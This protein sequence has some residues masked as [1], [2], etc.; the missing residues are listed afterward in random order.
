MYGLRAAIYKDLK[1][2]F[3]KTGLAALLLPLALLLA[4]QFGFEKGGWQPYVQPFPIAVRDED[5]TLMSRSLISQMDRIP[6]FSQLIRPEDGES[7]EEL[8]DSG[9]AAVATIPKD[10][11]YDLYDM[12]DCPIQLTLNSSMPL[13]ASL[14]RSMFCSVMDIIRSDQAAWQGLYAFYYG[15]LT[16]EQQWAM[17]EDASDSLIQDALRRQTVFDDTEGPALESIVER[18]LLATLLAVIVLF[19]SLSA[20]KTLPE[21]LSLGVLPRFRAAGGALPSFLLAKLLT[22]MLAVFPTLLLTVALLRVGN[23]AALLLVGIVLLAGAFG[24]LLAVASWAGTSAA[25]QRFGNLL[26]LLSLVFGGGL[27]PIGLLP[28]PLAFLSRLTLPYYGLLGVEAVCWGVSPLELF[29]LLLPVLLM[30]AAGFAVALPGLRKR[31]VG[32]QRPA[33]FAENEELPVASVNPFPFRLAGMAGVK[34]RAMSGGWRGLALL[35]SAA[36]LCGIVAAS[37]QDAKTAPLRIAV[38]DLDDSDSSR[39]LVELL[40]SHSGISLAVCGKD[41][42]IRLLLK[43]EVE[44]IFTIGQGYEA[45]L[46]NDRWE[47][48]LGYMEAGSASSAQCVREIIAGQFSVQRSSLRVFQLAR[49]QTGSLDGDSTER[50][51]ECITQAEKRAPLL[52]EIQAANGASLS[53]PFLPSPMAFASLAVLLTLFTAAPW[54]GTEGQLVSRRLRS[55]PFGRLLAYGSGCL[56]LTILGFLT[57]L[58]VL[59]PSGAFQP[60]PVAAYAFCAASLSQALTRSTAMEGRVDSFA[61]FLALFLCLL[62]GCFLDISQLSPVLWSLSMLTP[63]GLVIRA[64]SWEWPTCIFLLAQGAIF[65][66]VAIPGRK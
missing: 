37:A 1:L 41:E 23:I 59:L 3:R 61:P 31:G 43:G 50:L 54:S 32:R 9:A 21:E 29:Q 42:G 20:V 14:F 52:Y 5:N 57:A 36:L 34:L 24:L 35:L 39:K 27:W 16:N 51:M 8:L 65:L 47:P 46:E 30:G 17:Y 26:L 10:F 25:A 28:A 45:T 33:V 63:P 6:L 64:S 19:F 40:S 4:L 2:F 44:G 66:R 49:Q 15:E 58:A 13:E 12:Q 18:K 60:L 55:L 56:A 62:G 11:F 53:D 22:A 7:D 38:C 48:V